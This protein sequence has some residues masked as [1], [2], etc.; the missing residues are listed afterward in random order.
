MLLSI[1]PKDF[2]FIVEHNLSHIFGAF[3][4]HRV[5]INMMHNSAVSFA[6]SVDNAGERLEAL[7]NALEGEF[8]VEAQYG[9]EL[10]TIRYYDQRTIDRVLVDK[11]IIME[12]KDSLTCQLLVAGQ[13]PGQTD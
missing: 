4:T 6:V 7:M 3:H 8:K 10:I 12:L 11:Q 9:L 2:S 5:K 13:G 1:M